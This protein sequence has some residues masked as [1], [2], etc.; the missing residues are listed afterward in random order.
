MADPREPVVAANRR[1]S[2]AELALEPRKSKSPNSPGGGVEVFPGRRA[3]ANLRILS[4]DSGA[5][6]GRLGFAGPDRLRSARYPLASRLLKTETEVCLTRTI[7]IGIA[8]IG[9]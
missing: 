9:R 6:P 5:R 4:R 1:S 3:A 7:V 8:V 2:S